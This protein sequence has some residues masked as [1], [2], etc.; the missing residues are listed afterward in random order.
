MDT[1]IIELLFILLFAVGLGAYIIGRNKHI[2]LLR[3]IGVRSSLIMLFML[4]AYTFLKWSQD[5]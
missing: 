4:I 2:D 5:H 3:T 1:I